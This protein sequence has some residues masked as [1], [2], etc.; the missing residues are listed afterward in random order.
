[1]QIALEQRA[2][3]QRR[4]PVHLAREV[5]QDALGGAHEAGPEQQVLGR[6]AGDRELREEDEV[7]VRVARLREPAQDPLPVPVQVADDDIDL[8]E[9]EPHVFAR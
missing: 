6:V 8:G 1:V 2:A 3:D 5:A 9:R 7:G 4:D